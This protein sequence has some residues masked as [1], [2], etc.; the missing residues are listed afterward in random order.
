MAV[1][2]EKLNPF[3]KHREPLGHKAIRQ[4]V[5]TT[6]NPSTIDENQLLTVRFPNLGPEDLIVP[7]SARLAFKIDLE[8]A[9][10]PNRTIVNNLGRA[11]VKKICIKLEG[12]EI[13]SID[14]S[15]IF[16]IY[17]DLW[18]TDLKRDDLVYQG[19]QSENIAKLRI[20]AGNK[21]ANK[22]DSALSD[23]FKNRFYIP[24]DFELLSTHMPYCQSAL[25]D[26]LTYELTF[27]NYSRVILSSDTTTKYKISEIS[28]EYEIVTSPQLS[29]I[30]RDQYQSKATIFYD[31]V[32]RH[33]YS[34]KNKK[35][36]VWNINL[37]TP[38]RSMKGILML[39]QE[40]KQEYKRECEEFYN[41]KIKNVS[42]VIEGKPNQIF[43]SGV[44]P[45]YFFDECRKLFGGGR[46]NNP[47]VDLVSKDLHLHS[48]RLTAYLT[49]KYALWVDFRSTD[50][51]SLHGSGRRI[52]NGSEGITLQIEKE[53]DGEGPINVYTFV[54]SDAQMNIENGRL[55]KLV[56]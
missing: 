32:L 22:K 27:N 19:I 11:I 37:N 10:D 30:I 52:E 42:I 6:N 14:D 35:D 36:E 39:F 12:Q 55:S 53:Q 9:D 3:R 2:G 51:S 43:S 7:G 4:T 26:R 41:P 28:L 33:N 16:F 38:A 24:L 48:V 23:T 56:Y 46:L 15:D 44:S 34:I 31:R 47:S 21:T 49:D 18:L 45:H 1:Y 8:S 25:N 50:D 40:P 17:S 54:I 5:I 20:N 29:R 13:L